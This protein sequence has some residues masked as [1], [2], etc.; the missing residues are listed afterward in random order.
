VNADFNTQDRYRQEYS[1]YRIYSADG[2]LRQRVHN[3]T[4]TA[5]GSPVTVRLPPGQ[6]RV[7][8]RANGYG[9]VTVPVV[10]ATGGTTVIHLEGGNWPDKAAFNE[11]NAVRLPDGRIV[12]WRGKS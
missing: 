12:G 6:Y 2:Q 11:T 7:V 3:D 8:A 4:G 1:D 9:T 5:L 10:I